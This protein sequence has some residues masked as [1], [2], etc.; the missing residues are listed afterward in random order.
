MET[1]ENIDHRI[2]A[3]LLDGDT[4]ALIGG[5]PDEYFSKVRALNFIK[6]KAEH[7][8]KDNWTFIDEDEDMI[9]N[10]VIKK[11]HLANYIA[12]YFNVNV[13]DMFRRNRKREVCNA[14]QTYVYLIMIT[15]VK[16]MIT[17][18]VD[19][20]T[21]PHKRSEYMDGRD[22]SLIVGKHIGMHHASI[23]H[24]LKACQNYYDTERDYRIFI[25][26]TIQ[27]LFDGELIMPDVS[28]PS[29][30]YKII[31]GRKKNKNAYDK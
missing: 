21:H 7:L 1:L 4:S 20:L 5:D 23:Y 27:K 3:L 15:D 31:N 22:S 28:Q 8:F 25:D 2:D 16:N 18:P 9:I 11:K 19:F 29:P 26:N 6:D 17:I 24:T 12:E 10:Y 13:F 14:R 30:Y